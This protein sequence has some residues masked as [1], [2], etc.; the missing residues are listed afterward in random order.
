[1]EASSVAIVIVIPCLPK[2]HCQPLN[3]PMYKSGCVGCE[4]ISFVVWTVNDQYNSPT[5]IEFKVK[6]SYNCSSLVVH[7]IVVEVCVP[8]FKY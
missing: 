8:S 2:L 6:F 1:M 4:T 7:Y 3:T 5:K